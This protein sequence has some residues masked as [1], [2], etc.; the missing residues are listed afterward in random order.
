MLPLSRTNYASHLSSLVEL[1]AEHQERELHR[2][3]MASAWVNLQVDDGEYY[4]AVYCPGVADGLASLPEGN[5]VRVRPRDG[6]RWSVINV[7]EVKGGQ[8]RDGMR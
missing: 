1:E 7:C 5:E 8:V 4:V 3:N 6:L 2:H